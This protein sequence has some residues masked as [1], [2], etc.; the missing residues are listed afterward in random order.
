MVRLRGGWIVP[1]GAPVSVG[2]GVT[3]VIGELPWHPARTAA[4]RAAN[5]MGFRI[6]VVFLISFFPPIS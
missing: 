3:G 6:R 4:A 1:V 2:S 5:R